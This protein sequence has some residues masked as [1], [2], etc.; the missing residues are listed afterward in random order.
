MNNPVSETEIFYSVHPTNYHAPLYLIQNCPFQEGNSELSTAPPVAK[1]TASCVLVSLCQKSLLQIW[2][3]CHQRPS[4]T[5]RC[6][7][8]YTGCLPL[9]C[10]WKG[11]TC[12][13]SWTFL[14]SRLPRLNSSHSPEPQNS[15]T[16]HH[17]LLQSLFLF[18]D[19]VL[20][21]KGSDAMFSDPGCFPGF[22]SRPTFLEFPFLEK[23]TSYRHVAFNNVIFL[24]T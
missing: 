1:N 4:D 17:L 12:T 8:C 10:G 20:R 13:C 24:Y 18:S 19:S 15:G 21:H 2:N 5:P 11:W 16:C 9:T 3:C 6:P 7:F 23:H 22:G 14:C